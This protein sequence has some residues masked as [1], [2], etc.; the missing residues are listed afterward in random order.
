ME[1]VS[2][3]EMVCRRRIMECEREHLI[4]G[5]WSMFANGGK[6]CIFLETG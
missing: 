3:C 5:S 1:D 4:D 2:L 6:Q